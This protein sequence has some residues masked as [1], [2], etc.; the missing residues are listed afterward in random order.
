MNPLTDHPPQQGITYIEHWNYAMGIAWRLLGSVF[1]F[2]LHAVLPFI[3]IEQ[4][5]DLEAT[6]AYLDER[7][8]FIETAASTASGKATS[9]RRASKP[10]RHNTPVLAC[11][12]R[13]YKKR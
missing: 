10:N 7:N 2:P 8:H 3:S 9:V 6:A 5:L 13:L 1:A 4:H 11:A 12:N